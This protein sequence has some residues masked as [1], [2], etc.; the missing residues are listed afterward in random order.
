MVEDMLLAY[1]RAFVDKRA[2]GPAY[3]WEGE[4]GLEYGP[5]QWDSSLESL[6]DILEYAI[7]YGR[8]LDR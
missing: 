8:M 6:Y 5:G 3:I 1:A 7:N 4:V 2:E